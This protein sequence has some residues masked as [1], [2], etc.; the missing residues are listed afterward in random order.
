MNTQSLAASLSLSLLT[1][2]ASAC[3]PSTLAAEEVTALSALGVGAIQ[4]NGAQ[5]LLFDLDGVLRGHLRHDPSG[6]T[7]AAWG[8]PVGAH[9]ILVIDERWEDTSTLCNGEPILTPRSEADQETLGSCDDLVQIVAV[10]SARSAGDGPTAQTAALAEPEASSRD[11][12]AASGDDRESEAPSDS[13]IAGPGSGCSMSQI[14][15]WQRICRGVCA[16]VGQH[17]NGI[18]YCYQ[19]MSMAS[20]D[21]NGACACS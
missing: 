13:L 3:A 16:S 8:E 15:A 6:V 7:V 11:D 12:A 21:P 5:T 9:A 19:G 20:A 2:L 10:L 14:H 1:G 18:H 4:E 17:S